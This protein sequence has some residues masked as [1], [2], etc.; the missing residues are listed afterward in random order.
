M[1]TVGKTIVFS[2]MVVTIG[3]GV[4]CFS[5]FPPH[6]KLGWFVAAYMVVSCVVALVTLPLL[7]RLRERLQGRTQ[8]A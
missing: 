1:R 3:F 7:Y 5:Q 6:A 8:G 4:L 2:A